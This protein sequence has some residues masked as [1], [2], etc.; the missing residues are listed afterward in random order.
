MP[1]LSAQ[2]NWS[3]LIRRQ[4]WP[5]LRATMRKFSFWSQLQN[6]MMLVIYIAA[7]LVTFILLL[8]LMYPADMDPSQPLWFLAQ[9]CFWLWVT[10]FFANL[11]EA[12]AEGFGRA[13]ADS[14]KKLRRET[15][16]KKI[17]SRHKKE[18]I[19]SVSASS[20]REG[21]IIIVSEGDIIPAD[22]MVIE[23]IASVDESAITG[24]SAPV[25]R[26]AEVENCEVTGG[27]RILSDSLIIK[28]TCNPGETF[29]DKMVSLVEGVKRQKTPG[30]VSLDVL[31]V[32]ITL[33]FLCCV[34]SIFS[35]THFIADSRGIA[36]QVEVPVLIALFVCLV[37]TT[38]G[39]L[40]STITLAGMNRLL[41][42]N[43]IVKSGRSV[44]A[45]GDV[46]ILVL[47]KT[48]TITHGNRQAKA[49]YP[50]DG[51]E[52]RELVKAALLASL[53]D[54]TPEGKS[55]VKI[56][57]DQYQLQNISLQEQTTFTPFTAET[58]LSG[59]EFD[60][61]KILK[62]AEDAVEELLIAQG[63][64]MPAST[65]QQSAQVARLGGTPLIVIENDRVLGVIYLKD[66]IKP[67]IKERLGQLRKMGISS[68]MIT[69]DNPITAAAIAAE[70]GVDD[71]L[72]QAVPEKKLKL[73]RA[74]QA[75]G[76][77]VA[78][79]GDGT[80]DAPALAQSD[81]AIVMNNG[82]AAAKEAGNM[83]DLDSD[84]TKLIEIVTIG[85][86]LLMTRG[87]FTTLSF[88]TDISKYF[89]ILPAA[90]AGLFPSLKALDIMQLASPMSAILAAVIFNALVIFLLIPKSLVGVKFSHTNAHVL[91]RHHLLI[92]GVIGMIIPFI[93][94]KLI[95]MLLVL[96][97][98]V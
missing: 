93:G 17:P 80:N 28:V 96:V 49:F 44:E 23:G 75:E 91:L 21:D 84:P 46:D 86:Q 70:A 82:T 94:I 15:R 66:I 71:Y 98:M 29:I 26:E 62:G 6:P 27:T 73:I 97:G 20:L 2:T 11:A 32:G 72:A 87:A 10:L 14:L 13:H 40:L 52:E 35:I 65:S 53:S 51:V 69:G 57:R 39:A 3:K 90:F 41:Q 38:I 76:H 25:I 48:G 31:L 9:L 5:V 16:A 30:E 92:Y 61:N 19:T 4:A 88:S 85:R 22:G 79:I 24:E 83:I 50:A 81:V 68:I 43:V 42:L 78:M 58:R 63:S 56:A 95:N 1:G 67:G 74:K 7:W 33:V 34:V 64:S 37:P 18:N 8:K 55:I 77:L 59:I 45:A 47:D 54:M 89:A 60:G 36:S 12:V